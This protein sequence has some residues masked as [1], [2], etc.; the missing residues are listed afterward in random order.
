M[1]WPSEVGT[2]LHNRGEGYFTGVI[3]VSLCHHRELTGV[4]ASRPFFK[5]SAE[6]QLAMFFLL[7]SVSL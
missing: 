3:F 7:A 4:I 2:H 5:F 6:P 1:L